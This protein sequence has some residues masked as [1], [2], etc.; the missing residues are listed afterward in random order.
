M[1]N[2]PFLVSGYLL[3]RQIL[4][5]DAAAPAAIAAILLISLLLLALLRFCR[6]SR[7]AA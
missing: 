7:S 6:P 4:A 5:L 3:R 2:T 1:W